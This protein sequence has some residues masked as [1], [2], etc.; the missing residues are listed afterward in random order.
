MSRIVTNSSAITVF[1]SLSRNTSSLSK[2]AEK[3]ATGLRINRASDDAA[4]L[5]ISETMRAQIKGADMASENINNAINYINTTEG[6]LQNISD[7]LGRMEEL[8]VEYKDDTKSTDDKAN[9]D[10][11]FSKL[12]S[13][14]STI[15]TT[16]AKFNG[17][18]VFGSS[19]K[20]LAVG[21]DGGQTFTIAGTDLNLNGNTDYT[22][23]SSA[24]GKS[25][26]NVTVGQVQS[27]ITS[28]SK[29]RATLGSYQSQLNFTLSG[30]Q[31]YSENIS[32]SESRIR[33]VDV[34]KE[35]TNFSRYQ[36]QVQAG[37]AMLAQ[38]NALPQS[39]LGLLG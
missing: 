19:A 7:I 18:S 32:A 29:F 37:T 14:L 30:L 13:E 27:A 9:I 21:A 12:S 5:A 24:S 33:N 34:A 35:T 31:N 4:G 28:V 10:V 36:I 25:L 11:E 22:A 26:A 38:A 16:R 39:V 2:S 20:T 8:A 15:V 3:L 23:V 6:Y 17:S 1:K